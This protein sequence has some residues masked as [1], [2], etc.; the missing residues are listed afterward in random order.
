MLSIYIISLNK[1]LKEHARRIKF[2]AF[3]FL[4]K[5]FNKT[6]P[7]VIFVSHIKYKK[8]YEYIFKNTF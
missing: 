1:K 2:Q 8:T 4:F 7:N 6:F 5:P 3:Y